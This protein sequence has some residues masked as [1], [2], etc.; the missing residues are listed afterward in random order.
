MRLDWSRLLPAQWPSQERRYAS[1]VRLPTLG[2]Q[3]ANAPINILAKHAGV[4]VD[5]AYAESRR[6]RRCQS[7]IFRATFARQ[8]FDG[9]PAERH[10]GASLDGA[11]DLAIEREFEPRLH[12]L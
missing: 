10:A 4:E 11:S 3:P 12:C 7:L 5:R 1:R 6:V 9:F 8:S 2:L